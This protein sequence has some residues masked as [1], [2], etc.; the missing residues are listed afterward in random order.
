MLFS[1][2]DCD[3]RIEGKMKGEKVG[4]SI[5]EFLGIRNFGTLEPSVCPSSY[6]ETRPESA[7]RRFSPGFWI[8]GGFEVRCLNGCG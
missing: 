8:Y 7:S 5:F 1:T 3:V 6:F 4:S 2:K